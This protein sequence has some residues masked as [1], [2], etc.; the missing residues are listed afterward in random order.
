VLRRLLVLLALLSV[1]VFVLPAAG[2]DAAP[3]NPRIPTTTHITAVAHG[4][5]NSV[6]LL[7]RVTANGGGTPKGSLDLTVSPAS[8]AGRDARAGSATP[9]HKTVAYNGGRI[10][11]TGPVVGRGSYV[12]TASFDASRHK[13][14]NSSDLTRFRVGNGSPPHHD[15]ND[16]DNNGILPGTG[17]PNLLWL[18]LGGGLVL[19]GAGAVAVSR[20][21]RAAT[22]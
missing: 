11:V 19:A 8:A 13:F 9:W 16:N 4:P 20:R 2:A 17:G 22:A 14:L 5:G 12:A 7:V 10:S 21:E 15:D 1:A 6:T 3:Y 18:L